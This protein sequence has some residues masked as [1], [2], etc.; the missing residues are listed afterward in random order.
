MIKKIIAACILILAL[1]GVSI[2]LFPIFAS[3]ID[4]LLGIDGFSENIRSGKDN[5]DTI[6]TDIPE[7]SE[8]KSGAVDMKNTVIEWVNTT[9][10][11][12]DTIRSGAQKVQETVEEWK[13]TFEEAKEVFDDAS[14][15]VEK[16]QSIMQD[17]QTLSGSGS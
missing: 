2:F 1:Y 7:V 13:Q 15:K 5:F 10:E 8:F 17:V 9:K 11:K 3:K 6:V 12:I 16:I 4:S 14:Q